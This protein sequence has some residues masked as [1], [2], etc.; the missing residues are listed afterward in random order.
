MRHQRFVFDDGIA[1]NDN[2]TIDEV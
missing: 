2:P 1:I